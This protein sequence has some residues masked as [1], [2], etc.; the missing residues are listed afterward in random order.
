MALRLGSGSPVTQLRL[1]STPVQQLRL[2]STLIWSSGG[3]R[4]DFNIPDQIGLGA[5]WTSY[6]GVS[7]YL[8]SVSSGYAR[9]NVPDALFILDLHEDRVRYN[10]ATVGA[11]DG[12]VEVK[13][14]TMGD[15]TWYFPAKSQA[16]RRVSNGSFDDGVGIS[17]AGSQLHIDRRVAGF[18]AGMVACGTYQPGDIVRLVQVGN[19]HTMLRNGT[20]VGVWNDSAATAAKD[21]GHRSI[22]MMFSGGKDILGPRRFSPAFDYI[23]AV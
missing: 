20:D 6:G 9:I 21:S 8:A 14:A 1:G 18:D 7:P 22:G 23:E 13:I 17:T 16:M 15:G 10:A 19:V 11:D 3:I 12:Y 5:D 2:G 4:L